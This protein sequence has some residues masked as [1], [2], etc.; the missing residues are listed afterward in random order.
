[1]SVS[2]CQNMKHDQ[3]TMARTQSQLLSVKSCSENSTFTRMALIAASFFLRL[4]SW[5]WTSS[6]CILILRLGVGVC[7]QGF[8]LRVY[9]VAGSS[10]HHQKHA[11]GLSFYQTSQTKSH[12]IRSMSFRI[13]I[14][15]RKF[16]LSSLDFVCQMHKRDQNMCNL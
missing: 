10:K 15:S 11:D 2:A 7:S 13:G 4:L 8:R 5:A 3:T 16:I 1:M 9:E 12:S 14:D 6:L